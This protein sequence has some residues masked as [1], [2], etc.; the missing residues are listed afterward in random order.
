MY[1]SNCSV[2]FAAIYPQDNEVMEEGKG[3]ILGCGTEK[4]KH[5]CKNKKTAGAFKVR[6]VCLYSRRSVGLFVNNC[7]IA[8]INWR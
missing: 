4:G 6:T 1:F 2:G 5:K 3:R 8:G 7:R